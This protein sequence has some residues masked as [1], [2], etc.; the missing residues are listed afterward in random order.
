MHG[1]QMPL[2]NA[3]HIQLFFNMKNMLFEH[4]FEHLMKFQNK[5]KTS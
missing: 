2:D 3:L 5:M 1:R 4:M